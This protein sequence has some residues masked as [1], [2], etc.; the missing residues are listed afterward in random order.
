[1]EKQKIS[2]KVGLMGREGMGGRRGYDEVEMERRD[3]KERKH[4]Q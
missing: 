3:G 2:E 4:Y 1:M